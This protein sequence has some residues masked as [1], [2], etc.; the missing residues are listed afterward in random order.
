MT[1]LNRRQFL[2]AT[3]AA[4]SVIP[5]SAR[6]LK[7]VGVQ[8]YTVRSVIGDKTTETI[9]ALEKIGFREAECVAAN[10]DKV[11]AA[12]KQTKIQPVS[13]HLDTQLF[14]RNQ[15]K[16]PAA[17]DDAKK[18]GFKFAV[19]PYIAPQDRGGEDV[20]KKLGDTLNKAGEICKKS[21]LQLAYHNHAFEFEPVPGKGTLLDVLMNTADPKLVSLELDIMWSQ[22]GGVNPVAVL[23]KYGKRVTLMH[24][25]NVSKAVV[26]PQY[27]EKVPREAF[28][29]VGSG[30]ID[31]KSVLVAASNVQHF[32]VEQDQ[33][34][35][36]PVESLQK[37]FDYLQK[38]N[39]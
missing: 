9:Q 15:D 23:K 16:L 5:V 6:T 27:N 3:A 12:L 14:T 13:L 20:I 32:F 37:S 1:N 34:P 22:V 24:I 28:Q 7:T 4:A 25:K 2:A 36:N 26:S 29:D 19:C 35:G 30:V 31:I 38:L 33:T 18:K 21:G 11:W 39:Y 10:L 8:L 17:L